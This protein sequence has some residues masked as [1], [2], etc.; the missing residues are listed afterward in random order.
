MRIWSKK[1]QKAAR[2][3]RKRS[4]DTFVEG[5]YVRIQNM[6]NGR[7][8]KSGTIKEVRTADDG[9]GVSYLISLTNGRET[10][11]H[12]SHLRYN[13]NRYTLVSETRVRFDMKVDKEGEERKNAE[14]KK[15]VQ[16]L[17]L[18]KSKSAESSE[19]WEIANN[20]NKD[21]ET[22]IATRTRS[23]TETDKAGILIKSVLKR[24]TL[25]N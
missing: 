6:A 3:Q 13:L 16:P 8:D 12:R 10:I 23:K 18:Q 7:W 2:K 5:D 11:R 20:H 9:Q 25:E 24:R 19:T 1:Q 14:R 4:A 15:V 22:G 17:K 21:D